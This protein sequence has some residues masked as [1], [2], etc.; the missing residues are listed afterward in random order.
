MTRREMSKFLWGRLLLTLLLSCFFSAI[1]SSCLFS[2]VANSFE[3]SQ[4][5]TIVV[6]LSIFWSFMLSLCTVTVF[7]NLDPAI[8]NNQFYRLIAYYLL[9]FVAVAALPLLNAVEG[10]WLEYLA[11]TAPFIVV[12]TYFYIEFGKQLAHHAY[13]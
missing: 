4:A 5:L 6:L 3:G 9:P 8:A 2:N 10:H 13:Q 12:H 1:V 11:V 7:F